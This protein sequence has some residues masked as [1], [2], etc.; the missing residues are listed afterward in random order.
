[1]LEFVKAGKL[2]VSDTV[3]DLTMVV[4]IFYRHQALVGKPSRGNPQIPGPD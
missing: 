1:L 2:D 3:S 4:N